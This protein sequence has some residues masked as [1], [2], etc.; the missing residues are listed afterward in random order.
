MGGARQRSLAGASVSLLEPSLLQQME[1]AFRALDPQGTGQILNP[2]LA[3]ALGVDEEWILR[4]VGNINRGAVN[5][6]EFVLCFVSMALQQNEEV[7]A[8]SYSG[9]ELLGESA[10]IL[11]DHVSRFMA[12]LGAKIR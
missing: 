10:K 6:R 12:A 2:E 4:N 3:V 8:G 9:L 11:N 7:L 1:G 5:D